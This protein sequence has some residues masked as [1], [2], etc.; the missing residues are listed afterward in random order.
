MDLAFQRV[1][2]EFEK[3]EAAECAIMS[4][5]PLQEYMRRRDEFLIP[6]GSRT[7]MVLNLLLKEAKA[8]RILELG[9]AYG[10]STLWLA[11]AARANAGEVISIELASHKI[12]HAR[13]AVSRAGLHRHVTFHQGDVRR[14]VPALGG[15]FDF[16][17]LDLW[18][19]LYICAFELF[20]GKLKSGALVAADNMLI[21]E[22]Y[23]EDAL[24]YRQHV[25]SKPGFSS[26]LLPLGNGVELS[27]Y[28]AAGDSGE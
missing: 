23:K 24:A 21:P 7:G 6:I 20:S 19:E 12:E 3:R 22:R 8:R 27:R 9:T 14:I 15:G 18:K 10:Y 11:E 17:L 25:R 13:E 4:Q 16:V 26:V 2:T 28:E 5:I 1:L